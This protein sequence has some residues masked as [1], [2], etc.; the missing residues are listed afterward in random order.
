MNNKDL[1]ALAAL[2]AMGFMYKKYL[3]GQGTEASPTGERYPPVSDFVNSGALG[4][5]DAKRD[6]R[7]GGLIT[8]L[9]VLALALLG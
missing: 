2:G 9:L 3:D 8:P 4:T 6:I 1:A 5:A 7:R